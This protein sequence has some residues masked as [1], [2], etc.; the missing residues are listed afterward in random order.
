MRNYSRPELVVGFDAMDKD[1]YRGPFAYG[2]GLRIVSAGLEKLQEK[3]CR[4]NL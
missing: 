1:N 4:G 2:H 3:K